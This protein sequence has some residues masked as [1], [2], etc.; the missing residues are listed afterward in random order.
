ML[1]RSPGEYRYM[2]PIG[3]LLGPVV[4]VLALTPA[5]R[6]ADLFDAINKGDLDAFAQMLKDD[7]KLANKPNANGDLPL[8]YALRGNSK[9]IIDLLLDAGADVN[10]FD[11]NGFAAMHFAA[12]NK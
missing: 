12:S 11:A 9:K 5:S 8:H 1:S 6:G 10:A 2:K 3:R 7:P 4:M